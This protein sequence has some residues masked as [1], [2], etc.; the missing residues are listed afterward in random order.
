MSEWMCPGEGTA[1]AEIDARVGGK[2]RIVMTHV[3]GSTEHTGEYLQ[4]DR[5]SLLSFTWESL[6]TD[7]QSTIVTIEFRERGSGTELIL[8]HRRL[9]PARVDAHRNGWVDILRKLSAALTR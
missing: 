7:D 4:I 3:G 5:P 8:T 6:Y 2:F 1:S 9:P